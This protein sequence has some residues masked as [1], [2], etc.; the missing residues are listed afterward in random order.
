MR[1]I[2]YYRNLFLLLLWSIVDARWSSPFDVRIDHHKVETIHDLVVNTPRPRFSWKISVSD[3]LLQRNV[4]QIAY[5]MQLQSIKLTQQDKQFEWDS[6]RVISSQSI[7]VPYTSQSDLLPS[8]YYRFRVRVWITNLEEPSEWTHW[9]QFRTPIFNLQEYITKNDNLLWIGSTKINMNE[10]RKEFLIPN[11]SPIKSAIAYI[12]GL[13][14]YEFYLNGN[15]VDPS[16]K[17]DPGWTTYEKRT[18]IVSFDL[19]TNITPGMNAVGV[20]L[21]NGWYSQEQHGESNYG[22]PRLI[23]I[24]IITFESGEEMQVFSDRTWT[25]R[26]GSIKHDSVYNG[27]ICDSRNDRSNWSRAGFNDSL[28]AW[29][30]PEPMSSPINS[31]RNGM[32]VLQDMPPIRAGSDALHFEVITDS[33]QEGFLNSEDLGEIK[34]AKLTDGGT[35]KPIAM[36]ESDSGVRTFDLGQNMAGWCRLRFHGPSGFGVYIRHGEV[37]T[38][39]VISTNQS[40][41]NIYTE[42]LREATASDTYVLRGD[43]VNEIYE[44]TFT[45]HGFRYLSIFGSPNSLSIDD[46]ECPFVHSETTLK[47]HFSTSNPVVNQIQHNIQWGQLSNIMSLPTDCPQRNERRGWMGDA[48]L[49][50]DE[51]LYNFDLIKFYQNFLNLIIDVQRDDGEVPDFVPGDSYPPDP[52]WGTAL[53]T[54]TW[55]V[56]RH[57]NDVHILEA[58]YD[59]VVAYVEY[60]CRVY[61]LTGLAN[62]P[63]KYGDWVPPPPQPMTNRHLIS[64]FAFLHDVYLL[65]NMS[66]VLGK[67]EDTKNYTILYQK[68]AEEFH[69]V[70]FSTSSNF[71]ADGMQA[72]QV[73]ALA[74]PG[75]VPS[76]V[77]ESVINQLVNDINQKDIHVTTGIVST[78]QIYPVLSDNGHHDL[79]LEL[80]SSTTYPSYGYMFTNSYENAT[81]IWELWNAPLTGPG[82]NSRNHIMYGSVG[83]WFYSHLAGIDISSNIITIRPRMASETKKH[84]MSKL[85]CQLSTLYGLVHVSYTRDERDIVANS[86]LLHVTIPPN[87]RA[88]VIFE[89]LFIGGQCRTLIEG[90][91]VIWSSDVSKRHVEGFDIEKDSTTGLMTVYIGSGQYKFQALWQ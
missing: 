10:L 25:G 71:Y 12:S 64:S 35:L 24:L 1:Y 67:Q 4:Q 68:L 52:N 84:L 66:Q 69:Q 51:A 65:I 90:Q 39:P 59:H 11:A 70:F 75:V 83:A 48:A 5:Q 33:Q 56:Y 44:P 91:Q 16:R 77:R 79:A 20:K 72:A 3:N 89:P 58:Y 78:A 61:N 15:K 63:V 40:A 74:L 38:Q 9:I 32:I 2:H 45:V 42:N 41:R 88:R 14:Y 22:P 82:M 17:L 34:G 85:D 18:L 37:L 73:L 26:E 60:F 29:I 13:G 46:V 8:K 62:F 43:P 47:G 50:V 76:N 86:I 55:Q 31:S 54:I 6:E 87:A 30:I 7:H 49:S 19:S 36:W 57:Y 80:I 23:F 27:E 21:G 28:S 81:T 53:P